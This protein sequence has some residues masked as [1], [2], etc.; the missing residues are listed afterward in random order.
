MI[1]EQL[2]SKNGTATMKLSREL[3]KYSI[4]DR[5][6]TITEFSE[7]INLARGTIQN[8][9][10]NLIKSE[11]IGIESKGHMGSYLVKKNNKILLEFAGI[12]YV[13]GAMP[14]PYSKRYEGLASG[15][16]ISAENQNKAPVSL[17]YMRGAKSRMEMVENGR[18]DFAITS[19]FAAEHYISTNNSLQIIMSFGEESYVGKHVLLLHNDNHN[20]IHNGMKVGIDNDSIDHIE[21]VRKVC[22]HKKVEYVPIEYSRTIELV[23]NG[24]IDAT[25]MNVDEILDKRDSVHFVD[26]EGYKKENTEAV[27]VASKGRDEIKIIMDEIIDVDA[28]LNIQKLIL[29]D[30]IIPRY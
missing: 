9:L 10:K 14:L 28:V 25:I 29:D 5:I 17:A 16:I 30:K 7:Q 27:I 19:R 8:A 12:S 26:I 18:Y 23:K 6:P 11:A 3:L 22:E 4:G 20:G 2:L 24:D 21:L 15:I 1:N 13:V